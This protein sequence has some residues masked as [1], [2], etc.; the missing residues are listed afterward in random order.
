MESL[1][2][3]FLPQGMYGVKDEVFL[4]V[5]CVL[6]NSGLTDI[7]HMTL[8][9][10]E[11]KQLVKSSETLW[12]VQKELT[13]WGSHKT[14]EP[15]PLAPQLFLPAPISLSKCHLFRPACCPRGKWNTDHS[16]VL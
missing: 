12:S 3:F 10:E 6:G 1:T 13:L 15:Q 16:N 4:S 5:P 2:G 9:P 7:V 8:Q 14:N 11:E